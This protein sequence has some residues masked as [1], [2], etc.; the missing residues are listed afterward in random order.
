M[1]QRWTLVR[2]WMVVD[3]LHGRGLIEVGIWRAPCRACGEFFIAR[4]LV[5]RGGEPSRRL[6]ELKNCPRHKYFRRVL[7]FEERAREIALGLD[8]V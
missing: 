2:S 4:A 1:T 3:K 7:S 5:H 8:L 6:L